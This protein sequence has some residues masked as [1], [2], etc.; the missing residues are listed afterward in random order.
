MEKVFIKTA[1][2]K[3]DLS[4]IKVAWSYFGYVNG[5]EAIVVYDGTGNWY[6]IDSD[7]PC[8]KLTHILIEKTTL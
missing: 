5:A 8:K 3:V 2:E 6:K 1:I 4:K 7:F